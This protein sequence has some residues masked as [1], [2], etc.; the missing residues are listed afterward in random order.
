MQARRLRSSRKR[1][2]CAPVGSETLALQSQARMLALQ[3]QARMLALQLQARRLRSN[4]INLL[5]KMHV[6]RL[7]LLYQFLRHNPF[8]DAPNEIHLG[9]RRAQREPRFEDEQ[10]AAV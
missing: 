7:V 2:A 9:V 6:M 5:S 3:L 8:G 1:D 10:R 4:L